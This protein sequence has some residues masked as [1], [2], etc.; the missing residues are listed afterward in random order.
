MDR[1]KK[2]EGDASRAAAKAQARAAA[3]RQQGGDDSGA[4]NGGRGGNSNGRGNGGGRGG[5]GHGGGRGDGAART[6]S[7]DLGDAGES[8]VTPPSVTDGA[9]GAAKKLCQWNEKCYR[10]T[11]GCPFRHT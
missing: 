3:W 10:I 8:A 1:Q 6:Q 4:G 5:R 9:S 7:G 11:S 2:A